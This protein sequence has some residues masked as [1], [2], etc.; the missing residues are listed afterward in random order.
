MLGSGEISPEEFMRFVLFSIFIGSALGSFP[1]IM[2]QL[3]KD[4][5][6]GETA[7][8]DAQSAD[9]AQN[10]PSRCGQQLLQV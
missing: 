9:A 6:I 5:M 2:S 3:Q 10:R 7:V 4:K 8:T 1:E